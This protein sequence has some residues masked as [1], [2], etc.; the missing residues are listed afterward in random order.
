MKQQKVLI[1][2][3]KYGIS[4]YLDPEEDFQ[5]LLDEAAQKFRASAAFFKDATVVLNLEGRALSTEELKQ[6]VETITENTELDIACLMSETEDDMAAAMKEALYKNRS[7]EEK[8]REAEEQ[9]KTTHL[10]TEVDSSTENSGGYGQFYKGTLR[11]G[12]VVESESSIIVM[13]D[14]NPGAKVVARGNI[15]IL[16]AL[17]GYAYAGA[18]GN[19]HTFVAAL[20]MSPMQIKIGDVLARNSDDKKTRIKL[21]GPHIA[22]VQEGSVYIE[23]IS[24]EVLGE[25]Q[26]YE[27]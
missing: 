23:E 27:T 6:L 3:N 2:G 8:L 5:K 4:V 9:T 13:G 21:K 17:K 10:R 7:R 19:V 16:G 15:V 25:I 12:Q 20:E 24:K 11:S 26:I 18:G 1:K 14:I 22:F